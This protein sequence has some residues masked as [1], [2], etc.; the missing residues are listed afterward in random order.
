MSK[1]EEFEA[2]S[3][4]ELVDA[5]GGNH[6]NPC[7]RGGCGSAVVVAPQ[8][9]GYG[10]STQIPGAPVAMQAQQ[11]AVVSGGGCRGG[12]GGGW[13]ALFRW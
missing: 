9:A 7:M 2:I 8:P 13:G 11:V 3:D 1:K 6:W 10:L 4:A 5:Q 12:W